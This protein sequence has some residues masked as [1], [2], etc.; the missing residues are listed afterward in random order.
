MIIRKNLGLF[1]KPAELFWIPGGMDFSIFYSSLKRRFF[2]LVSSILD[3]IACNFSEII[4]SSGYDRSSTFSKSSKIV[5]IFR[6]CISGIILSPTAKSRLIW[7]LVF[8]ILAI[9]FTLVPGYF[10]CSAIS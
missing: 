3:T 10:Y 2:L 9:K 1:F 4:V 7:V 6:F 5:F 8:F